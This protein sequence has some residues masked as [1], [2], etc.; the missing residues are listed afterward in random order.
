MNNGYRQVDGHRLSAAYSADIAN[1]KR[2]IGAPLLVVLEMA[3]RYIYTLPLEPLLV[4]REMVNDAERTVFPLNVEVM[5]VNQ[6][7]P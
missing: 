4:L 5:F 7:Q 2:L 1:G 3:Y 6:Q